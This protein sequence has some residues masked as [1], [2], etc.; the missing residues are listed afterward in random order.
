MSIQMLIFIL[1]ISFF[2]LTPRVRKAKESLRTFRILAARTPLATFARDILP[3]Q[4]AKHLRLHIRQRRPRRPLR[5]RPRRRP[6]RSLFRGRHRRLRT[7]RRAPRRSIRRR[8]TRRG[9]RR[10]RVRRPPRRGRRRGMRPHVASRAEITDFS[11]GA[12]ARRRTVRLASLIRIVDANPAKPIVRGVV[13]PI[14]GRRRSDGHFRGNFRGAR[15]Q[16]REGGHPTPGGFDGGRLVGDFGDEIV[17][18]SGFGIAVREGEAFFS[19]GESFA[20]FVFARAAV[21]ADGA[22]LGVVPFHAAEVI[23]FRAVVPGH[24]VGGGRWQKER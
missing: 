4:P 12:F 23:V 15:G 3:T 1:G 24:L 16:R 6:R 7:R 13:A 20:F 9:N 8:R 10:R 19:L 14:Q 18:S 11:H 22:G 21:L 5:R 2:F 17:S